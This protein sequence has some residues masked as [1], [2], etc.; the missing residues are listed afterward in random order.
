MLNEALGL[1][2]LEDFATMVLPIQP[3]TPWQMPAD[4]K[5]GELR[6]LPGQ[7][8]RRYVRD[9]VSSPFPAA[10]SLSLARGPDPDVLTTRL[11]L[12]HTRQVDAATAYETLRTMHLQSA[13][14]E[15]RYAFLL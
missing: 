13:G 3:V 9:D 6:I 15:L 12:A 2:A 5:E 14:T 10:S 8:W 1:V 11:H 7:E 4:L